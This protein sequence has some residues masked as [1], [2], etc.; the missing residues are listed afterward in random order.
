MLL[1]LFMVLLLMF[2]GLAVDADV[3]GG[4]CIGVG[5]NVSG[6]AGGVVALIIV[7]SCGVGISD[8]VVVYDCG[9]WYWWCRCC[10]LWCCY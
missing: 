9:C 1:L 2:I 4:W 6:G 3:V 8:V 10:Y 5:L 7:L